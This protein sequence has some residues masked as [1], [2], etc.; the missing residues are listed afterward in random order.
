MSWPGTSQIIL[1]GPECGHP[2]LCM[3]Y[4]CVITKISSCSSILIEFK[5]FI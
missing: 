1:F 2:E 3:A 5:D 4:K